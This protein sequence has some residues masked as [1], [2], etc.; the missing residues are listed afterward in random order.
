[1]VPGGSVG[2]TE[3]THE[4]SSLQGGEKGGETAI[5]EKPGGEKPWGW[6]GGGGGVILGNRAVVDRPHRTTNLS[7]LVLG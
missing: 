7:L 6:G 4:N 5:N 3:K 2:N 1:M